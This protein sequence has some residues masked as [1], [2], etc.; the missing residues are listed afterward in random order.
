M[1][2]PLP[3]PSCC[4]PFGRGVLGPGEYGH[5]A[6]TYTPR[7]AGVTS[8][9]RF[10]LATP[11]G[12]RQPLHVRGTAEGPQ[13]R[14]GAAAVGFGDVRAGCAVT[15]VVYLENASDVPATYQFRDDGGGVFELSR[16]AGVVP[17]RSTAHTR[18]TFAP[19]AAANYWRRLVCLVK[20]RTPGRG[21]S[22]GKQAGRGA[23][24]QQGRSRHPEPGI[25]S[26]VAGRRR[27]RRPARPST[28]RSES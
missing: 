6:V 18:V 3:P 13:L 16:P 28:A 20:V 24:K 17:P 25:G 23:G 12:A 5:L 26:G 10:A 22:A 11:S 9:A 21:S 27:P 1:R 4:I 19:G 15:E 7:S 2:R 8:F 14:L